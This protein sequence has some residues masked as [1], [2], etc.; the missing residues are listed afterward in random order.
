MTK[1]FFNECAICLSKMYAVSIFGFCVLKKKNVTKI[2]CGHL[3]HRK[4]ID[5]A[6]EKRDVCPICQRTVFNKTEQCMLRGTIHRDTIHR[7]TNDL[8]VKMSSERALIML[9]EAIRIN[10]DELI[11]I[12]I[13]RFDPS[14]LVHHY[15]S[16]RDIRAILKL[17]K[18]KCINHHNTFHGKTIVDSAIES[19]DP[20]IKQIVCTGRTTTTGRTTG[21]R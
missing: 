18:S 17:M 15:I 19:N 16:T 2:S 7:D 1:K 12:I 6:L 3:F 5:M 4:C 20:L 13:D 21:R 11:S 14:E 8:V 10:N 9:K